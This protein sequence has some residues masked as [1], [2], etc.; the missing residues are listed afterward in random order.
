MAH[1]GTHPVCVLAMIPL[2]LDS[3]SIQQKLF[4]NH[5]RLVVKL[6]IA[7]NVSPLTHYH[8]TSQC[9]CVV[10]QAEEAAA[11]SDPEKAAV[12]LGRLGRIWQP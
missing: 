12:A 4:K 1:H 10:A 2:Y 7:Q 3:F 5:S 6:F 8:E 11:C 9:C